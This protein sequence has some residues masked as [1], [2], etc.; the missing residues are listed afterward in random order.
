MRNGFGDQGGEDL[1]PLCRANKVA[2]ITYQSI[3]NVDLSEYSRANYPPEWAEVG[4]GGKGS[5]G[6]F[7]WEISGGDTIYVADSATKQIVGMGYVSAPIGERAYRFRKDSPIVPR[8]GDRWRHLIDVDW[9]DHF[10]PFAYENPRAPIHTV[11]ELK[12]TEIEGFEHASRSRAHY[13]RGLSEPEI[14]EAILWETSYSRYTPA[15]LRLI[16]REHAALSNLFVIWLQNTYGISVIQEH[17]QVDAKFEVG[18]SKFLCEFKVAYQG[19]TKRAIREALGQILEY[20]HYPPRTSHN[21]WL[22]I[23]NA[24]PSEDDKEYLQRLNETFKF[25]LSLGWRTDRGF[26]FQPTFKPGPIER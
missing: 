11:L 16:R 24:T 17:Q 23:L 8:H 5:M 26:D 9:D 25:P 6:K 22:L 12:Q 20:N 21:E 10:T 4:S 13:A 18:G 2:A 15:A 19:N 1:W 7:A 14:R 3:R